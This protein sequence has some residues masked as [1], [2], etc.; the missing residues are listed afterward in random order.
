[1]TDEVF[2]NTMLQKGK[3]AKEKVRL[4]FSGISPE[5]LNWKPVPG[6]RSIAQCLDHLVVSDSSYFPELEKIIAGNYRMKFW[7][8][9]S[10]FTGI[11]GRIMKDR[12]Q[13][14]PKIKMKAPK[15]IQPSPSEID[16]GIFERYHK[17]IDSFYGIHFKLLHY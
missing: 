7:E 10:P 4:A 14:Q 5:Q 1:M 3:E 2:I 9:Y 12:L 6:K 13:E 8:K 16:T 17:N 11:M 15:K